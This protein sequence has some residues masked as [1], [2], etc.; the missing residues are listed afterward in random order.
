MQDILIELNVF[1]QALAHTFQTLAQEEGK[2]KELVP[3]AHHL[4]EDY[5][6]NHS[7]KDVQLLIACCIADILR[8]FAPDAPYQEPDEIKVR[9]CLSFERITVRSF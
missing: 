4:A 9:R 3:L 6:L 5:F 7:S 1:M 8:I 2:Y